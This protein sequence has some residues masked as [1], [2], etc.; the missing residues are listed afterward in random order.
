M[1]NELHGAVI[2]CH[3][4]LTPGFKYIEQLREQNERIKA[5]VAAPE[6]APEDCASKRLLLLKGHLFD[7]QTINRVLDVV[8]QVDG[9]SLRIVDWT[10]GS[11][12]DSETSALL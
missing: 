12:R 5:N 1:P 8:E 11:D 7:N 10:L 6:P 3:G 9:C 2:A 4:A